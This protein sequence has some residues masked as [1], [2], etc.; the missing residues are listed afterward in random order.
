MRSNASRREQEAE[1]ERLASAAEK[2]KQAAALEES[3]CAE[4]AAELERA[5]REKATR[6]ANIIV[7]AE[8]E[9]RLAAL[10]GDE[11]DA[12]ADSGVIH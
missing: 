12:N 1:A 9:R 7:P 2:V 11:G 8:I 5:Q 10:V 4:R 3:Y 6:E